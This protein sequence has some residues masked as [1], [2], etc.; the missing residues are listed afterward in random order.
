MRKHRIDMNLIYDHNPEDFLE[1]IEDFIKQ[2][3][4]VDFLNLFISS[5]R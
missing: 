5:L 1:H 3:D 2:I 4:N